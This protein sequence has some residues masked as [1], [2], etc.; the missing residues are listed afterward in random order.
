MKRATTS[1]MYELKPDINYNL[2]IED[3]GSSYFVVKS[4][5]F[6][7]ATKSNIEIE[8]LFYEKYNIYY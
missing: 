6:V 1:I 4:L 3:H 7:K 5:F 2:R 8:I